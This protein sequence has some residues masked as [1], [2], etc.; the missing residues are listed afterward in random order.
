MRKT[1]TKEPD[2]SNRAVLLA[3]LE[4]PGYRIFRPC[5]PMRLPFRFDRV[6]ALG[7]D[8]LSPNI[9]RHLHE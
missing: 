5:L 7:H 4:K 1:V 8:T 6:P 9:E 3:R 2:F